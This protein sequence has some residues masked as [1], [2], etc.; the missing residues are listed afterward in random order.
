MMATRR[1]RIIM[2]VA[3][4][5]FVHVI[6]FVT[7]Q[8][9]NCRITE[10]IDKCGNVGSLLNCSGLKINTFP[11]SFPTAIGNL[12][13][14]LSYNNFSV[15]STETFIDVPQHI[16]LKVK[17]ISLQG[18]NLKLINSRA[19]SQFQ[20]LC[21]L[22][23][24]NCGLKKTSFEEGAFAESENIKYLNLNNNNF[25]FGGYP[26]K[27]ITRLIALQSL[28]IDVFSE[29]QFNKSFTNL[30]NLSE[31]EFNTIGSSFHLTNVTFHGL[32][33]SPIYYINM[34]FRNYVYCDITED[35]FC[36]FP[37]LKGV[38][39]NIAGKCDVVPA[40][41]ALKCLQNRSLE[42]LYLQNNIKTFPGSNIILSEW[43]SEY[44]FNICAKSVNISHNGIK[45]VSPDPYYT[46]L[47][48]CIEGLDVWY[49]HITAIDAKIG[50]HLLSNYPKLEAIRAQT[51]N[52]NQAPFSFSEF[53]S[54]GTSKFTLRISNRLRVLDYSN[55]Y[56]HSVTDMKTEVTF[57]GSN[58]EQLYLRNTN[59]PCNAL[60]PLH[61]PKLEI[62]DITGNRCNKMHK[63]LF[64]FAINLKSIT[65]SNI[66][67]EIGKYTEGQ[68]LFI[69][70]SKLKSLD[71]SMNSLKFLP[72]YL[73]RDQSKSLHTISLDKNLFSSIPFTL[74][75]LRKLSNL[76]LRYNRISSFQSS[77]IAI[78]NQL[79][80]VKIFIEGN[81]ISCACSELF[82]LK[83]MK[84]NQMI[85]K[86]LKITKCIDNKQTLS[87]LFQD[88]TFRTFEL[89]CQSKEWL[90][91]TS[92]VL[93]F[94][95]MILI[96]AGAVKRYRVHVDYVIL[97]L[98]NRWKGVMR[99]RPNSVYE[100]DVFLSHSE[101]DYEWVTNIL[102]EKL[103]RQG[104]RVSLP[105]KDFIPGL[106]K[107]KEMLR[108]IDNSRKVMFVITEEFLESGWESYAV[109]MTVTHA[110]HNHKEQSIVVLMKDD[111]SPAK[112]PK[113]LR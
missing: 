110:F 97:Q 52:S 29:F 61:T 72:S 51:I 38:K 11:K 64:K 10:F 112:M 15:I 31:V 81:P 95:I 13:I 1:N 8:Q 59:F 5:I 42:Y 85:I 67:L 14:D 79:Q 26:E 4:S 49:N 84:K 86:D 7:G 25:Q 73:F 68:Y 37:F 88:A 91:Y 6:C 28:L 58:L 98:R 76:S 99:K 54:L 92:F 74:S 21:A 60:T 78:I 96:S 19:F 16:S 18:N 62:I 48:K 109:Q 22:D 80:N 24:S 3:Q 43:N 106:S 40:L 53:S 93:F 20:N 63:K 69:N 27:E 55:N 100:F 35:L 90:I 113:D 44:L 45:K 107:A 34:S 46:R 105:E 89:N 66:Q 94:L 23:I 108:C 104:I 77:D 12:A 33:E 9:N 32:S 111:I 75:M 103:T 70:L 87:S 101:H 47:G 82:S 57:I 36:S 56:I 50:F 17:S 83:W 2:F 102:Y 39:M 65:A 71:L 30:K 41:R